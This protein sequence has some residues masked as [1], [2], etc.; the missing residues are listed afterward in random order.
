MHLLTPLGSPEVSNEKNI[1]MYLIS[2]SVP[3]DFRPAVGSEFAFLSWYFSKELLEI[4]GRKK[5][6][7][8]DKKKLIALTINDDSFGVIVQS[9]CNCCRRV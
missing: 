2:P 6:S 3:S 7:R 5:N 4:G 8:N 9:S 1:H